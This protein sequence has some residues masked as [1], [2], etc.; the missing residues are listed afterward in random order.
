MAI[1]QAYCEEAK[2]AAQ[3]LKTCIMETKYS[4]FLVEKIPC[5]FTHAPGFAY[6][7]GICVK[8]RCLRQMHIMEKNK[9]TKGKEV[10]NGV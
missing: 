1:M 6:K 4:S 3:F 8:I 9:R 7:M 5:I 10:R 2:T